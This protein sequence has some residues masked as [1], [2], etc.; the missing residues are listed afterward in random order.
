M[1]DLER[2]RT[3]EAEMLFL[4]IAIQEL[5][6]KGRCGADDPPGEKIVLARAQMG[7]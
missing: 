4:S 2:T 7:V 3:I 5:A 1:P 6:L